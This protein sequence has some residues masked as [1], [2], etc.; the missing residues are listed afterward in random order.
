MISSIAVVMPTFSARRFSLAI[1]PAGLS[2]PLLIFR[3]VLRRCRLVF[4][5]LLLRPRTR[6]EMSEL[7]LVLMRLMMSLR[8]GQT[9]FPGQP[10]PIAADPTGPRGARP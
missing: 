10:C 6:C 4:N 2:A 7:T 5:W 9:R 1:K 3:P 8:D